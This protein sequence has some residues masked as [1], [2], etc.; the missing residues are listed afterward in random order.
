K[1]AGGAVNAP[2]PALNPNA[3]KGLKSTGSLTDNRPGAN[4]TVSPLQRRTPRQALIRSKRWPL[5]RLAHIRLIC[6]SQ[7]VFGRAPLAHVRAEVD[8]VAPARSVVGTRVVGPRGGHLGRQCRLDR[9]SGHSPKPAYASI[10][11]SRPHCNQGRR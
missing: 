10:Q 9:V 7:R 3:P 11:I 2:A 4:V 8:A 6:A 5:S 1:R